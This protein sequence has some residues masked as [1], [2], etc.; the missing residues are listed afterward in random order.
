ME[1][2]SKIASQQGKNSFTVWDEAG[3]EQTTLIN[4]ILSVRC[5]T[6][7]TMRSKMKYALQENERGKMVPVKMGLKPIQRNDV[8]YEFD[9]VLNIGR[10][11]IATT[12][13]DT[14]FLDKYGAVITSE[15]GQQLAAWLDGGS[16]PP[17]CEVCGNVIKPTKTRNVQR[18]VEGTKKC[19][20]KCMC[21]SCFKVWQNEQSKTVSA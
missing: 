5:H 15:L 8:E 14:T 19:T 11:H 16:E 10:N 21:M 12:S 3:A 9:I 6:I 20:G 1:I 2:K 13:K 4:S 7:I 17:R 18:I